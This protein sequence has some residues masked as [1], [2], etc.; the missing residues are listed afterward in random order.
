M[1]HDRYRHGARPQPARKPR[2]RN[3]WEFLNQFSAPA[4]IED[5]DDASGR[6]GFV[7][8]MLMAVLVAGIMVVRSL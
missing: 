7:L 2:P 3:L 5:T 1:F 4:P 8:L 6:L